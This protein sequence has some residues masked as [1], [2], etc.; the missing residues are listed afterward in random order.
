MATLKSHSTDETLHFNIAGLTYLDYS[1]GFHLEI[2]CALSTPEQTIDIG[3]VYTGPDLGKELR[4]FDFSEKTFHYAYEFD[5]E[6][7]SDNAGWWIGKKKVKSD[8]IDVEF[9]FIRNFPIFDTTDEEEKEAITEDIQDYA[10]PIRAA[11]P[12]LP[13]LKLA[14]SPYGPIGRNGIIGV[15]RIYTTN[16]RRI[17]DHATDEAVLVESRAHITTTLSELQPF[18]QALLREIGDAEDRKRKAGLIR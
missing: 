1:G 2:N 10:R 6:N 12:H 8:L 14:F 13:G 7:D 9:V 5:W 18:L 3:T 11:Q 4:T 15:Q 16:I 17:L